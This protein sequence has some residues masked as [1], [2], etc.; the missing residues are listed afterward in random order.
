M[1]VGRCVIVIL[2]CAFCCRALRASELRA[3]DP[4]A[5]MIISGATS[6]RELCV[7]VEGGS[8]QSLFFCVA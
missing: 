5:F 1:I 2:G 7:T 4:A 6:I 8:I 3:A